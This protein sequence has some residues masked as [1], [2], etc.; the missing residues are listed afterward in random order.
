MGRFDFPHGSLSAEQ[1]AA[2][3]SAIP[4]DITFVDADNVVR[5]YSEYRIFDRTPECL[6]QDVLECH[7]ARSRPGIARLIAEL[8][9]GWRDEATFL[10]L[11]G[12]CPVNVRYVAQRDSEGAYLGVVEVATWAD[13]QDAAVVAP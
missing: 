3:F 13:D 12:G 10:E 8:R 11:K 4:A 2:V 9:D 6:G 1:A 5:Y 7:P